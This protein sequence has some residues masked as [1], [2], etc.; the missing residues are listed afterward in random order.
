MKHEPDDP[1]LL[2]SAVRVAAQYL[3]DDDEDERES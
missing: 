2:A 3:S 1:E